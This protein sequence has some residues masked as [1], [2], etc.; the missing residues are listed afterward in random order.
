[1]K[2]SKFLVS[3]LVVVATTV[4]S[5]AQTA[6]EIAKKHIEA[7]GGAEK[8]KAIK[9][10][11]IKNRMSIGG[12]DVESKSIILVGK[13]LRT[14][15]SVMGQKIVTALDGDQGWTILPSMMGGTGEPQELPNAVAKQTKGQMNFGG[16][17]IDYV[18][19]GATLELVGKEKVDNVEA[20]RLKL[21]E[22][23]GDVTN[24]FVS[25]STY[26]IV[27]TTASRVINAK[28]TDIELSFSNFK[29]VD[30]LIF[31]FTTEIPSPM[32]GGQMTMEVDSIKLNPTID[33]A[34]FKKPSK[35]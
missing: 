34:I 19:K 16:A 27:K 10:I 2:V 29:A 4:S 9:G 8:W 17:L 20:Y 11:E 3:A 23:N 22:K 5:M 26:Y 7:I 1:M 32:G 21:T 35:K 24:V 30:G 28:S 13:G 14:E 15:A 6:E 31:P 12:M 18:E 25:P 33:E